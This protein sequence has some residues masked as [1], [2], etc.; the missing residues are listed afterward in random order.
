[1]QEQD[2]Q[3]HNRLVF[4]GGAVDAVKYN[5]VAMQGGILRVGIPP[6]GYIRP[7][8]PLRASALQAH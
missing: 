4:V 3:D 7:V 1:M 2:A 8:I 6:T 5:A